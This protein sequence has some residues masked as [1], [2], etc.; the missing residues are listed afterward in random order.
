MKRIAILFL[1]LIAAISANSQTFVSGN[2]GTDST[3]AI[4]GSPYI[5]TGSV[6]VN[7]GV[8][9]TV[10]PGVIV[11]FQGGQALVVYGKLV[12]S[13]ATFTSAKDTIGGTPAAGDWAYI[14]NG[15]YN[16][17]G[18]V[19]LDTCNVKYGGSGG[20]EIYDYLGT[21]TL[22]DCNV[23]NSSSVGLYIVGTGAKANLSQTTISSCQWPISYVGS[24]SV[25]FDGLTNTFTG[26]TYNGILL[27]FGSITGTAMVLDTCN[28]PY[29]F[30]QDL[31]IDTGAS[32]W[33]ANSNVL[34]FGNGV[35]IYVN[36]WMQAIAS[37][38]SGIYF[39]AYDD[40]NLDGD[41]N[42]DGSATVPVSQYWGGIVFDH[43]EKNAQCILR[44][45]TVTFAGYG[46]TGGVSMYSAS[47]TVD[48]CTF[49]KNYYGA[50]MRDISNPVF[51]NNT[52]GSS[53]MVPV[54]MSFTA[55]PVFTNNTLS[56]EDNK[57]DAIGILDASTPSNGT[58]PIRSVTSIPNITYLLLTQITIP[59]G[60]TFT[61]NKGVVIK[62]YDP[63]SSIRI[64][65]QGKLVANGTPDSMIVFTSARDDAFGNPGDT[66]RDGTQTSPAVSDW[67][68]ISFEATSD[69]SSILNYCKIHYGSENGQHYYTL[70]YTNPTYIYGGE[71]TTVNASPN[72]SNCEIKDVNYGVFAFQSSNPKISN[73]SIINTVY[74]PIAMSVNANPV[75]TGLTFTNTTWT[76]LG[77]IGEGLGVN[78]E[79]VQRTVAGYTNITYVLL[80]DL[81]V[82][83]GTN[84]IV[85]PGVVIK[86]N[87]CGIFV[88]GGFKAKG[89]T[90]GGNV[91]FTSIKDDN[92]GNPGDTN[93]DGSASSAARGDWKTIRFEATSND[94]FC[95]L[96]SCTI[97]FGG[98]STGA[99]NGD[100]AAWGGVTFTNANTTLS[101]SLIASSAWYGVRC[102]GTSAPNVTNVEMRNCAQDPIAMSL[103]ANPTFAGIT[104][105]SNGSKGIFIIEGT[106][107]SD[108]TLA[109]RDVAGINNIAY[110]VDQL[111][112]GPN[113][114]LTIQPGVVIKFAPTGYG[115]YYG[116]TVQGALIAV[117]NVEEKIIFTSLMDDSNG[118]DT[119]NDGNSTSPTKG[120]WYSIEFDNSAQDTA[121]VLKYC[122]VRYAGSE[123]PNGD[124]AGQTYGAVRFVN[125]TGLIDQCVVEQSYSSGFGIYGSANPVIQ[126][127]QIYNVGSTPITMSMFSNPTFTTNVAALNVGYMA[128]GII[129]E[130]YSVT[131][132]VPVRSFSG[133][134]NITYLLYQS[135]YQYV[136]NSGTTITIPAGVV[137]KGLNSWEVNGALVVA[138]TPTNNVVFTDAA[139]DQYGNPG[140]TNQDGSATHP[141]VS[142]YIPCIEFADISDDHT[143][144]VRNAVIRYKNQGINL[145]Q[146]SPVINHCTFDHDNWGVQL[147][148]VSTPT[149]DSC[150]FNNLYFAPMR[151]SLVSY[152]TSTLADSIRG[153]T[154]RAIGVL[155]ETLVQDVTLTKKNFGGYPNIP[156]VFDN[157]TIGTGA[158]LTINPGVVIKFL[159][160]TGLTVQKGL[161]A[162]GSAAADSTIVFTDLKDDFY[163]G[164][165]NADSSATNPNQQYY[166]NWIGIKFEDESLDPFCKLKYCV[167][168]YTASYYTY[169]AGIT[170]SSASPTI[171]YCSINNNGIGVE[172]VGAS[173]PVIT[174]CDIYKNSNYGVYNADGSF[175]FDAQNN[176]WGNNS[177]PTHH[178]NPGGTGD[179]VTD[180]V[181]YL[182]FSTTGSLDPTMG[183]VSLNGTIQAFDASLILK[184]V[185]NPGA[186]PLNLS[187]QRVADVSGNGAI[188]AF[189][190]SLILQYVVGGIGYFPADTMAKNIP[191]N[192]PKISASAIA[193]ANTT[194]KRG[195]DVTIPIHLAHAANFASADIRLAYDEKLLTPKE[196]TFDQSVNGMTNYSNFGKGVV[197]IVMATGKPFDVDGDVATVTFTVANDVR[198]TVK[199][200]VTFTQL[201]LN[202]KDYRATAVGSELTIIGKPIAYALD[203]NFPNP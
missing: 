166:G 52:I 158:I 51:S 72:I 173:N 155:S 104:F 102:E 116:I 70:Y 30:N 73:T 42:G 59:Q 148:G 64:V 50:M 137:F 65:V 146:A 141:T 41:T 58:L 5:V 123:W 33:V 161:I 16:D 170:A 186:N 192:L 9:L 145:Q 128:L 172:T 67:G 195:T 81:L 95:L 54:A 94:A 167:V 129:P 142:S 63:Y 31:T 134:A 150:M 76:A 176:W 154:Y 143:C 135:S 43:Q 19:T 105:T 151:T 45:C 136:I 144:S 97:K 162:I 174:N 110:I 39:T 29:V 49:S 189:D 96:D 88:D 62:A 187:Q 159:P 138:G 7:S 118:G 184:Y 38:G 160:S 46:Q 14:Q 169:Y 68:G 130:T 147:N 57:Y 90:L 61:I 181:N 133:Y 1:I 44:R 74:T 93:G 55:S 86:F 152:P 203:Q 87:A 127:T 190:G 35:H 82:N 6:T 8:Q 4:G 119:N 48:S 12:A 156:Y 121:D 83:A 101:N 139:D 21:A 193:M 26:N 164:D 69:T 22:I 109:R 85:D 168:R 60:T 20:L 180:S 99:P 185:V 115:N 28:I 91:V 77:I 131:A 107:S 113:A 175:N 3:W 2:I 53:D 10:D 194:A 126:N 179:V 84:V 25:V 199:S 125:S 79:I 103:K 157:Y 27:Q 182:P 89:T 66:N 111:T 11:R 124:P 178:L 149:L 114:T 183:D 120:D 153:T 78:G 18:S 112:I 15:Y 13:N 202:E 24:G 40:D 163:G 108:A 198:G 117:G 71:I 106:L 196:V 23:S 37:P 122:E 34:K 32:L 132:T 140:D 36:G 165:T 56:F 188:T 197:T 92:Y 98:S 191:L 47:P 177:G 201:L 75:M 200:P 17:T 100:Y 171:T 80:G